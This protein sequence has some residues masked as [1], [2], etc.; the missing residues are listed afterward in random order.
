MEFF[1]HMYY[2]DWG[3]S[4]SVN[5]WLDLFDDCGFTGVAIT[6]DL[7]SYD[8]FELDPDKRWKFV[9]TSP[10][11]GDPSDT[12]LNRLQ[13]YGRNKTYKIL[14]RQWAD[15]ATTDRW[16]NPG[17][18][19]Y[20]A[21]RFGARGRSVIGPVWTNADRLAL[22]AYE[23]ASADVMK[24]MAE[25]VIDTG[26]YDA[27]MGVLL[28]WMESGEADDYR[29][30]AGTPQLQLPVRQASAGIDRASAGLVLSQPRE[31]AGQRSVR[32]HDANIAMQVT[33]GAAREVYGDSKPIGLL[34]GSCWNNQ[35]KRRTL[36]FAPWE[37][38]V[39]SDDANQ[40]DNGACTAAGFTQ[41]PVQEEA[42]RFAC[43]IL[44]GS[45]AELQIIEADR[46]DEN[47]RY[48]APP[49]FDPPPAPQEHPLPPASDYDASEF[50]TAMY[51]RAVI[52]FERGVSF[53]VTHFAAPN[54]VLPAWI[55]TM[56]GI[57][58]ALGS[59]TPVIV[60]DPIT[61]VPAVI[62]TAI[63]DWRYAGGGAAKS[64]PVRFL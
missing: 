55:T 6:E 31:P 41:S 53:M 57:A 62:A 49:P 54:N 32:I 2:Y 12:I 33:G 36:P 51:D 29:L 56:Q 46:L 22:N 42:L 48:M 45:G 24:F 21:D 14:F 15:V 19:D 43:D 63:S 44:R 20:I 28:G 59:A 4:T 58:T 60:G 18:R 7:H 16:N 8:R 37:T 1:V 34:R 17:F 52:C 38:A 39:Q 30:F 23:P 25:G 26:I 10:L 3:N 9:V 13:G 64:V 61:A 5:N 40:L 47:M 50:Q 27:C 11:T 35:G